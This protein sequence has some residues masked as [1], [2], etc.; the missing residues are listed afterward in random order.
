MDGINHCADVSIETGDLDPI[1]SMLMPMNSILDS[2][3]EAKMAT[4]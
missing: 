4:R 1:S 3:K 2:C